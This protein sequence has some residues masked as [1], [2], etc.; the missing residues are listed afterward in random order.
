MNSA[1]SRTRSGFTLVE[2]LVV[3]AI[4]GVLVSLLLPAVQSAREA[5]RR[6]SCSNNMRQLGLALHNYHDTMKVFPPAILGS[7]RYGG[8]YPGY[9]V[10]N[11]TGWMMM[12]SFL[13]QKA[14]ADAYN[15]NVP[16][17][18]SNGFGKP[19]AGGVSS[20]E[21]NKPY[22]SKKLT[23]F[24]CPSDSEPAQ[25][26]I[27]APNSADYYEANSVARSNYLFS[28]GSFTD[29]DEPYERTMSSLNYIG[30]FGNDGAATIATI[31]DGTSNSIAVGESKQGHRGKVAS[32]FGPYWGAGVHTCC[33]GRAFVDTSL[34]TVGG[35][36]VQVGQLYSGI[37]YD[38]GG[39]GKRQQY[40]WQF[41]SYH[42]A[43][44]QFTM[45]DGSVRFIANNVDHNN[46]FVKMCLISDGSTVQI[47]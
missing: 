36:S 15:F 31:T 42:P 47:P 44:A 3:I 26:L 8:N 7:G 4:I 28:T 37:N 14:M 30:A 12:I 17:S 35:K 18:T 29:Y 45:C 34:T 40:A 23:M 43:G 20:S 2:L 32:V 6:M 25:A 19:Y 27:N 21:A 13:E 22:Y 9:T 16:A 5:A 39:D 46:I 11:T 24:T 41:G 10:A 33:H 1:I 38:N